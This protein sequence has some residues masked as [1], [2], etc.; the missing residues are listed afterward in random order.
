MVHLLW[1]R[2]WSRWMSGRTRPSAVWS[3]RSSHD[4]HRLVALG[5]SR[6]VRFAANRGLRVR[7]ST[8]DRLVAAARAL[9]CGG[10][11]GSPADDLGLLA[12]LDV[13]IAAAEA[14]LVQP[15]PNTPFAP[16]TTVP[17]WGTVRAITTAPRSVTFAVGLEPPALP[18]LRSVSCAMSRPGSVVTAASAAKVACSCGVR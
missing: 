16:L 12:C 11:G 18:C 8:A 10:A 9:P 15:L 5:V 4:P 7:R 1:R 17:G 3:P 2:V 14:K 6:F 13:Q